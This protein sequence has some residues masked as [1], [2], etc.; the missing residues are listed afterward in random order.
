MLQRSTGRSAYLFRGVGQ[1]PT[2]ES[3]IVTRGPIRDRLSRDMV[4]EVLPRG[5]PDHETR[6]VL[7]CGQDSTAELTML[8]VLR[9]PPPDPPGVTP[10]LL[11]GPP[12]VQRFDESSPPEH[13]C[14]NGPHQPPGFRDVD[15]RD[16]HAERL[17]GRF[18]RSE[19][20]HMRPLRPAHRP[21][22]SSPHTTVIPDPAT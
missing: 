17:G 1:K 18:T 10:P 6:E 7:G 15:G 5:D 21:L 11:L 9:G 8:E 2:G 16:L 14:L 13:E 4:G 20:S 22:P 19:I 3:V 12:Q